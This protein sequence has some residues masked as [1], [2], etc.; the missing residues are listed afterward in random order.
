[1]CQQ[2]NNNYYGND[3]VI[4]LLMSYTPTIKHWFLLIAYLMK[5]KRDIILIIFLLWV[6]IV[7]DK[8]INVMAILMLINSDNYCRIMFHNMRWKYNN[9]IFLEAGFFVISYNKH[10]FFHKLFN[11]YITITVY[12]YSMYNILWL[13]V[14]QQCIQMYAL[15]P[16]F[17]YS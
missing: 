10:Y 5:P 9:S 3:H 8:N 1:M 13:P 15:T 6:L 17:T 11:L 12:V 2:I 4:L 7:D 16:N 14:E